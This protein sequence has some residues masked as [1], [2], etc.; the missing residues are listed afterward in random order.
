[1]E[2]SYSCATG[3]ERVIIAPV[4]QKSNDYVN[5]IRVKKLAN[6]HNSDFPR[7]E[8]RRFVRLRQF[9]SDFF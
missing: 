2:I 8:R 7:H 9:R 6:C 3:E 4:E 1:M 5:L